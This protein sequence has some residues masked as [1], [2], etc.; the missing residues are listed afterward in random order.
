MFD[1]SRLFSRDDGAITP[2]QLKAVLKSIETKYGALQ[3]ENRELTVTLEAKRGQEEELTKLAADN[4]ALGEKINDLEAET[5][6]LTQSNTELLQQVEEA[7][8]APKEGGLEALKIHTERI[9]QLEE[10]N[11]KLHARLEELRP[12]LEEKAQLEENGLVIQKQLEEFKALA[13]DVPRLEEENLSLK[14]QLDEAQGQI[15]AM[16]RL[17]QENLEFLEELEKLETEKKALLEEANSAKSIDE[18]RQVLMQQVGPLTAQLAR[19][20]EENLKLEQELQ[21]QLEAQEQQAQ[22]NLVFEE[23]SVA[24]KNQISLLEAEVQRLTQTATAPLPQADWGMEQEERLA[25]EEE[26]Q[27]LK[28]QRDLVEARAESQQLQIQELEAEVARL[29]VK[30]TSVQ[31]RWEAQTTIPQKS[32]QSES[33]EERRKLLSK[34]LRG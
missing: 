29:L 19:L 31:P 5:L 30:P 8:Q 1:L 26:V 32:V 17:E 33:R 34:M 3:E 18:E 27:R 6:R 4:Q 28:E 16:T 23:E 10:E 7:R 22:A 14:G 24:L 25:L 15:E 20:E 13:T 9:A 11:L 21:Q 12:Q 2:D